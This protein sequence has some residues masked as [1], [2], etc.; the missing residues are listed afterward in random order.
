MKNMVILGGGTIDLA[1]HD[2]AIKDLFDII[3]G[4]KRAKKKTG[5]KVDSLMTPQP[6]TVREDDSLQRAIALMS[7]KKIKRLI[8]TDTESNVRDVVS[9]PDLITVFLRK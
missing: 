5:T 4:R 2:S 6:I 9:R 8:V 1:G 7:R 3:I